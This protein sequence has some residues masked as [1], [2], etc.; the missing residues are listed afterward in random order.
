M[1]AEACGNRTHLAGISRHAGF[2][3]QEGHQAQS[4]SDQLF[5]VATRH[6]RNRRR[7]LCFICAH[8]GRDGRVHLLDFDGDVS[9]GH[10]QGLVSKKSL[11]LRLVHAPPLEPRRE[12]MPEVV[13]D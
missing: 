13:E 6:H 1:V 10:G 12:R 2:E 3:D 8:Q 5:R 4:T 9:V 11:D 7:L